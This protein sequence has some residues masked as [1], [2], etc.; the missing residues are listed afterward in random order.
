MD[1]IK[2]VR[3]YPELGLRLQ[4]MCQ[5]VTCGDRLVTN[6]AEQRE[7]WCAYRAGENQMSART[8]PSRR[9]NEPAS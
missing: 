3:E 1:E 9:V 8:M 6:N 5:M 4:H 7:G 2:T